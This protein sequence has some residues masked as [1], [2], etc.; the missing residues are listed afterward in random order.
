MDAD[1]TMQIQE[2]IKSFYTERAQAVRRIHI[3]QKVSNKLQKEAGDIS[4][5]AYGFRISEIFGID[6]SIVNYLSDD[7]VVFEGGGYCRRFL[8]Q[9]SAEFIPVAAPLD[10]TVS[11][12]RGRLIEVGDG[13]E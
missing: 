9:S 2:M 8:F 4:N 11:I 10:S 6:I 7:E 12:A 1:L 13:R 5:D 3:N